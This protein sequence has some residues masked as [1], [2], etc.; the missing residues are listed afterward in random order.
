MPRKSLQL[1]DFSGGLNTKSS[2]RDIQYN[3]VQKADNVV[4]SNT[5]LIEASSDSTT[6]ASAPTFPFIH[7]QAGN[8]AFTFNSQFNL[9][10]SGTATSPTQIIAYPSNWAAGNSTINFLS[11]AFDNTGSFTVLEDGVASTQGNDGST[12]NLL[13]EALDDSETGV[14]VDDASGLDADTYI[15]VGSEVMEITSISSNTLTV[16]RGAKGT[17]AA[18]HSDDTA[19]HKADPSINM[20]V[21]GAIQPVYYFVDGVLY[22]SDK[23]VVDGD[24]DTEPRKLQYVLEDR[25]VEKITGWSDDKLRVVATDDMFESIESDT[26]GNFATNV[27]SAAGEF[28]VILSTDP[29]TDSSSYSNV[30]TSGAANIVT[31]TNPG[32]TA[33]SP[34]EDI[35]LTDKII[36][37]T[38]IGATTNLDTDVL[39]NLP[40][41]DDGA[42]DFEDGQIIFI[43]SEAMKIK[44]S[45]SYIDN[46]ATK[47][48][49]QLV[50][51]RDIYGTGALEHGGES[52]VKTQTSS[53]TSVTGGGWE[54]GTYE[55]CH[56]VVDLQNNETLPITTS[57][58]SVHNITEGSYFTKVGLR[59]KDTNFT[60]R[61]NEKGVRIYTRKKGGNGRW[62][63]FL[64]A[65][66]RRGIRS[67][68]F[69][70]YQEFASEDTN[71]NESKNL[72][73]VNPSL[74]T[75]E[76]ITGYSQDEESIVLGTGATDTTA[77]GF[78]A[79][80]VCARR[81]WIANVKKDGKVF[82][83]RIYY[84][85]TN[86]FAT[87]P[88]SY[89][90]DIGISDGDAFTALHS[91]GNRLLAFKHKKLYVINVSSSSDAGWYLEAE[92]DGMGCRQQESISK[93]PFGVCWVNDD[94]VYMFDGQSM[95]K[96]LTLKLDDKTWRTNQTTKNPAIGYNNKYKQ[97]CVVQDAAADTDVFVFDF[98]TQSW[99][100]TKSI[101][102]AGISNFLESFDGLY[103]LEYGGSN[104]KT[105][106]LLTGDIGTKQITL[107]TKDIDFGNP[108]LVK[109]V[110]KVYVSVKDDG[111]GNTLTL[112]YE[113][114]N[115]RKDGSA[116]YASTSEG[117]T[118]IASADFKIL[119]YTINQSCES[120]QLKLVDADGEAVV[121]NDINI[122]YRLTNKR[123]S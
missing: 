43:N 84:T 16:V 17:T 22:V 69:E 78:K 48:V 106:K 31:T 54:A 87:F 27:P 46:S 122:D 88:D 111:S 41:E 82:D 44:G 12:A 29:S 19:V 101:G 110:K 66:Y 64:D 89:Y 123:P 94:G 1:N 60:T 67:N 104:A 102:S 35:G 23:L 8:G 59:L 115:P 33:P 63:L 10:L 9:D 50:V 45:P 51:D 3:E 121:I 55:F 117:A 116:T 91:F 37:L 96:E 109:K 118:S 75:Y 4:L 42:S 97:L 20:K 99:S 71:Y 92:Y 98:P 70:D 93:T 119:S 58:L 95:P 103:Y 24:N 47:D 40:D 113:T 5:G 81:A 100:L 61:K 53:T 85:P 18:S 30:T 57:G 105:L 7:T 83:D 25:F 34:N 2:P 6:K 112:T 21:T 26:D 15:K 108:G 73:I 74:D 14:D 13:A 49:V 76:S 68:L 38:A 56:T 77:G 36:Y 28:L 62:I 39:L 52:E 90:L 32:D 11:R 86:R 114:D 107:I 72:D 80:T 65:D 120:I 79:A